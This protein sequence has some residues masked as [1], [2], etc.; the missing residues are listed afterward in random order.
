[1][2]LPLRRGPRTPRT[3][4]PLPFPYPAPYPHRHGQRARLTRGLGWTVRTAPRPRPVRT[5]A[6]AISHPVRTAPYGGQAGRNGGGFARLLT[7][8]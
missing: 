5:L 3:A 2:S 4:R 7:V 1:M 6:R 8:F